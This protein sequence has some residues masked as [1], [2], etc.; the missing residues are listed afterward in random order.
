MHRYNA[1]SALRICAPPSGVATSQHLTKPARCFESRGGWLV[2]DV[3]QRCQGQL[4]EIVTWPSTFPALNVILHGP[5]GGLPHL[6]AAQWRSVWISFSFRGLASFVLPLGYLGC[7]MLHGR[8]SALSPAS[9]FHVCGGRLW[10]SPRFGPRQGALVFHGCTLVASGALPFRFSF[11]LSHA[12]LCC[13]PFLRPS[14]LRGGLGLA[15]V[16]GSR[17]PRLPLGCS[18]RPRCFGMLGV[19]CSTVARVA[20]FRA[21]CS[22][23]ALGASFLFWFGV[24]CSTVVLCASLCVPC[25][26]VGSCASFWFCRPHPALALSPS[27]F[28]FHIGTHWAS[29]HRRSHPAS[30]LRQCRKG[31]P[32]YVC[33]CIR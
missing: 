6:C 30:R 27:S 7:S 24:P 23:V 20:A 4:S 28:P 32:C 17:V 9:V 16:F 22:A 3:Q 18:S 2:E 11:T 31:M 21:P 12:P 29:S 26:T 10:A 13:G 33:V 5:L 1:Q 15:R 25:S 19:P 14:A 8:F